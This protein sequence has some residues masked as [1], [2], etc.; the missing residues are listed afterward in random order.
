[1]IIQEIKHEFSVM[2]KGICL[3]FH[4]G[5]IYSDTE[6]PAYQCQT[7]GIALQ[8]VQFVIITAEL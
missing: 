2:A 7:G 3:F 5:L 4:N 8:C 1:V 6:F